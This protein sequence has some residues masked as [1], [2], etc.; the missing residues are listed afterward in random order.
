MTRPLIHCLLCLV[1]GFVP[2]FAIAQSPG[3]AALANWPSWRGPL[4]NGVAPAGN[5]PTE[6]SESKNIQW[7]VAIPGRGSASPVVWGDRVFILTAIETDRTADQPDATA[8]REAGVPTIRQAAYAEQSAPHVQLAVDSQPLLAQRGERQGREGRGGGGDGGGNRWGIVQ[9]TNFHQFVVMCID[10]NSG[11]TLWQKM[12]SEVIPHEGHH[13]TGSFAPASPVT[14]GKHLYVSFGSRGIHCYDFDGNRIWQKDLGKMETNHSFGEGSSPALHEDTLVVNWDHEG[15]SFVTALDTRTGDEK[16]RKD[17]DEGTTWATPLIVPYDGGMQVVTSGDN[18]IRAYDLE[19]GDLVWECG[20]LGS[21]A[22]PSP[23]AID[24]MV[25]CMTGFREYAAFAIPVNS[26]GD[27]TEAD[28]TRWQLDDG[29][30]YISSPLLY[31]GLLYIT[32]SRNAILTSVNARTGE[33][34]LRQ[35]RLPDMDTLYAAP[36]A[37]AGQIYFTSR[38]GVTV[39]IKHGPT[40]DI[41]ATNQLDDTFDATPAIV[42]NQIFLRGEKNL[43]CIAQGDAA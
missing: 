17:R 39:V 13:P 9:P 41:L 12:A 35:Q 38:E 21:N 14:D 5:P 34:V 43:Y 2:C 7:K 33:T 4:A 42:G 23:V 20:G 8:A 25:I 11:K 19:S 36:V 27:I 32:K 16:W 18:R 6:W 1:L 10:R 22:I 37:A 24:D 15:Q 28:K 31:D 30:P 40:L 3:D 26:K 29:T